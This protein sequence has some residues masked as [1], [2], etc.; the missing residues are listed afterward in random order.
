MPP[1]SER[2]LLGTGQAAGVADLF[3]VLASGTQLR[4]LHAIARG[5]EVRAG[6]LAAVVGMTQQAAS[7]QLQRLVDGQ[8]CATRRAGT[9]ILYRIA[10][11]CAV[12][13]MNYGVC[14]TEPACRARAR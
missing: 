14:V 10:D 13:L 3:K 8:I 4:L 2:P 12:S 9:T 5:G 11:P 1:L 7:S 6:E